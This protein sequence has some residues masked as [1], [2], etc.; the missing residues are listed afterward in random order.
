LSLAFEDIMIVTTYRTYRPNEFRLFC[1]CQRWKAF[2]L[3]VSLFFYL[4]SGVCQLQAPRFDHAY[5][6]LPNV[7]Q[8]SV[9]VITQDSLGFLWVGTQKGICKFEGQNAKCYD[10]STHAIGGNMI[11]SIVQDEKMNLWVGTD[12]GGLSRFN[13]LKEKFD[14]NLNVEE[15]LRSNSITALFYEKGSPSGKLWIGTK[16]GLD[17]WDG[18]K[19]YQYRKTNKPV[20]KIFPFHNYGLC[21]LTKDGVFRVEGDTIEK[22]PLLTGNGSIKSVYI[23][24]KNHLIFGTTKGRIYVYKNSLP[25]IITPQISLDTPINTISVDYKG[26][27]W[28]GTA[29]GISIFY[30]DTTIQVR[31]KLCDTRSLR[32][33]DVRYIYRD[34]NDGMWVGTFS[35]SVSKFDER[36]EL[37]HMAIFRQ[38][39]RNNEISCFGDEFIWS[40]SEETNGNIILGT[41][42]EG[43]LIYNPSTNKYQAEKKFEGYEILCLFKDS[44]GTLWISAK[45]AELKTQFYQKKKNKDY[46]Y[47]GAD[48]ESLTIR[49]ITEYKDG[50]ILLG[51]TDE[52]IFKINQDGE[53]EGHST[54]E[55]GNLN[56]NNVYSLLVQGETLWVGTYGGGLN[57]VSLSNFDTTAFNCDILNSRTKKKF[58]NAKVLCLAQ[59][60]S[61]DSI[62]WI[63]TSGDGMFR[64]N[65][66]N[67]ELVTVLNTSNGLPD[68]VIYTMVIDAKDRLWFSTTNGISYIS[69]CSSPEFSVSNDH[70]TIFDGLQNLE[71]NAGAAHYDV[72]HNLIYMG[73]ISGFNYF[74]PDT[75]VS[76]YAHN[77]E[78]RVV[79]MKLKNQKLRVKT[80]NTNLRYELPKPVSTVDEINLFTSDLPIT[81]TLTSLD[82]CAPLTPNFRAIVEC[83][84]RLDTFKLEENEFIFS[85][86]DFLLNKYNF[87]SKNEKEYKIKFEVNFSRNGNWHSS[88]KSQKIN[89]VVSKTLW[90]ILFPWLALIGLLI[91]L[92]VFF[93]MAKDKLVREQEVRKQYQQKA[94]AF[95][96]L[97]P[98]SKDISTIQNTIDICKKTG[99]R[100]IK[101][102]D[103]DYVGFALA[104]YL[105]NEVRLEYV[106]VNPN[107]KEKLDVIN[108]NKKQ[109]QKDSKYPFEDKDILSA[110]LLNSLPEKFNKGFNGYALVKGDTINGVKVD[111]SKEETCPLNS[112]VYMKN[113]HGKM[114]RIF[115]KVQEQNSNNEKG[116]YGETNLPLGVIEAGFIGGEETI[117]SVM[118]TGIQTYGQSFADHYIKIYRKETKAKFS[119]IY[120]KCEKEK[121]YIETCRLITKELTKILQCD[122]AFVYFQNLNEEKISFGDEVPIYYSDESSSKKEESIKVI[123]QLIAD[124]NERKKGPLWDVSLGL[125]SAI[126]LSSEENFL[127]D[128][129]HSSFIT[130]LIHEGEPIGALCLLSN[131]QNYFNIFEKP[132]IDKLILAVT[133]EGY[134]QKMVSRISELVFP[135]N[136]Y[137]NPIETYSALIDRIEKYMYFDCVG[138]WKNTGTSKSKGVLTFIKGSK[139][140]EAILEHK[141]AD[142]IDQSYFPNLNKT[143]LVPT[144]KLN[145]R[146]LN[147]TYNIGKE[148]KTVICI[149]AGIDK[150]LEIKVF[151]FSKRKLNKLFREDKTIL[152]AI[153]NKGAITVLYQQLFENFQNYS[154]ELEQSDPEIVLQQVVDLIKRQMNA[155]QVFLFWSDKSMRHT[156]Y[157][158]VMHS[159]GTIYKQRIVEEKIIEIDQRSH[160][161]N[162]IREKNND[163]TLIPDRKSYYNRFGD[164]KWKSSNYDFDF[165]T[166]E[167]L[168]AMAVLKLSDNSSL[169]F[170]NYLEEQTFEESFEHKLKAFGF[171]VTN[172]INQFNISEEIRELKEGN[173]KV[174]KENQDSQL[175]RDIA[176]NSGNLVTEM[177]LYYTNFAKSIKNQNLISKETVQNFTLQL[178]GPMNLL[179]ED[180]ARLKNYRKG[181]K[182]PLKKIKTHKLI[183]ESVA[184]LKYTIEQR[185]KIEI[186]HEK[187]G[188]NSKIKCRPTLIKSVIINIIVNA[189]E[190]IPPSHKGII[191]ISTERDFEGKYAIIVI[192]DNGPGIK[193]EHRSFVFKPD[194]TTKEHGTGI[195]LSSSKHIIEEEHNGKLKLVNENRKGATFKIYLPLLN[196]EK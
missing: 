123:N 4:N 21:Y 2:L 149:P 192:R 103:F 134:K 186:K 139:K 14:L 184:L 69:N 94:G 56:K 113:D 193:S 120:E 161:I 152:E 111:F 55:I 48:W 145:N 42:G 12:K 118:V 79:E 147:K 5:A 13:Y 62:L 93:H 67:N 179:S 191:T 43:L 36:K 84:N 78:I 98:F 74:S 155:H 60:N 41:K 158:N 131:K 141:E 18:Q 7:V 148:F 91:T 153:V 167:E 101:Q 72:Q 122:G 168:N 154:E 51:T 81:L 126:N 77:L 44:Q 162:I 19:V 178:L 80:P 121:D 46:V 110:V 8:H 11:R 180:F 58:D 16:E 142:F 143:V 125:E 40:I 45:D 129:F 34:Q 195:G 170:V 172:S 63:G 20:L 157:C 165:F 116:I 6:N 27:Y 181:N 136:I 163:L 114:D 177:Y 68:D 90:E 104:D 59:S 137:S 187:S 15:D 71:F 174:N 65:T 49:R 190:A 119:L 196:T 28:L 169:L 32:N 35:G 99:E 132:Y 182:K 95:D 47:L 115:V 82:Y 9:N 150:G 124:A 171:L 112:E 22:I 185:T 96:D 53:I 70:F 92:A 57:K 33:N 85:L 29:K 1:L 108:K 183:T 89:L 50:I 135:F 133:A 102:Y 17:Y 10:R 88:S 107:K 39:D 176:H 106:V 26:R 194:F 128:P 87:I 76:T 156:N 52:G 38:P 31:K 130:P 160:L 117:T 146:K 105:L 73:G 166:R 144:E 97:F 37:F 54:S 188:P 164:R 25:L 75:V 127:F 138:I 109:W 140:L 23:I 86:N 3:F 151:I 61:S 159:G 64:F 83:D 30:E 100:L 66:K 24:S 173:L 189:L 175:A